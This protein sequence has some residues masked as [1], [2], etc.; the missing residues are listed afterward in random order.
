MA[1]TAMMAINRY[2][3]ASRAQSGYRPAV[4]TQRLLQR[5]DRLLGVILLGNNFINSVSA[6]LATVIT[7]KLV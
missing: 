5:T 3:L 1:E 2:R 7:F 6:S 4:L